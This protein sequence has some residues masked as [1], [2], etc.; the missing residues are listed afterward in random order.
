M[1]QLFSLFIM[2]IMI[3][4][5]NNEHVLAKAP[6]A[7]CKYKDCFNADKQINAIYGKLIKNLV[8]NKKRVLIKEELD[9]VTFKENYCSD[10]KNNAYKDP[11]NDFMSYCLASQTENRAQILEYYLKKGYLNNNLF[12]SISGTYSWSGK[13]NAYR[14]ISF[15]QISKDKIQFELFVN[16][17]APS[18]NMGMAKGEIFIKN[19]I[20]LYEAKEYGKC[21]ILIRFSGNNVTLITQDSNCGFGNGVMA[22]GVFFKE[23]NNF[24]SVYP[25]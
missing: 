23:S 10:S 4:N 7:F 6:K 25:K 2:T 18:F 19:N 22:D 21:K 11:Y 14:T 3:A 9:W 5:L 20:A 1:K 15:K 17:G 12:G 13:S 24:T 8:Q 16:R